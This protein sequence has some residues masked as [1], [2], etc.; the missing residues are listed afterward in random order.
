MRH[1]LCG[2][3]RET[4]DELTPTVLAGVKGKLTEIG[5]PS[6]R[7]FAVEWVLNGS[8][9]LDMDSGIVELGRV[10]GLGDGN[11][12]F[13]A[14]SRPEVNARLAQRVLQLLPFLPDPWLLVCKHACS[15]AIVALGKSLPSGC[16]GSL[17]ISTWAEA[18]FPAS[19]AWTFHSLAVLESPRAVR[20][21]ATASPSFVPPASEP[22]RVRV[23]P[24]DARNARG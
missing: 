12:L 15:E 2:L 18:T 11:T 21:E 19:E 7:P 5:N 23:A 14:A 9:K 20:S 10:L 16:P 1:I 22:G 8:S 3:E 6:K 17:V 24:Q 13:A 4:M